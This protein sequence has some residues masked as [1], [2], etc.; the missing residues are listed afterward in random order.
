MTPPS[1]SGPVEKLAPRSGRGPDWWLMLRKFIAHGTSIASFSPS[2]K[3]LA[4]SMIRGI[5][6]VRAKCVV[7]LGAGTGPI[8]RE[9]VKAAQPGTKLVI[10]ERD[11]DFC[12]LLREKFPGHDIV[13][14][15]ACKLDE[16]LAAR[17]IAN[18]DHV[19]SGLP[20]PSFPQEL[21]DSIIRMSAKVLG[22]TGEFR[23]ITNMPWVYLN[24][25]RNYFRDV[26]FKL[27]PLN[28]PPGGVYF[29]KGYHLA[30]A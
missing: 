1:F 14:G 28:L 23:Q 29:C 17:G 21:R 26:S 3:F 6:W 18:A 10:V 20:L 27:V 4:R 30:A 25:Y 8:T 9:L 24:L 15:D 19:I 22:A 7:E 16:I 12:R 2:S 5:D 11:P 13:E